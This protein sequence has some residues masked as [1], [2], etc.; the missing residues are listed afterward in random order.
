MTN[1]TAVLREQPNNRTSLLEEAETILVQ[2]MK[3]GSPVVLVK[4]VAWKTYA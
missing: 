3:S 2:D 1:F 4:D